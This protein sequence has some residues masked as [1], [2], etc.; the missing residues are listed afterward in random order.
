MPQNIGEALVVL[1]GAAVIFIYVLIAFATGKAQ[2]YGAKYHRHESPV[3]FWITVSVQ[4]GLV[5]F[6]IL[7]ALKLMFHL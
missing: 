6:L 7:Y 2:K 4:S 3:G 5:L 1:A